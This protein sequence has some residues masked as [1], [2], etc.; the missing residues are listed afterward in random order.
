M[1]CP[2]PGLKLIKQYEGLRLC[3]YLDPVGVPTIGFGTTGADRP[4]WLGMPCITKRT[5]SKWLRSSVNHKYMPAVASVNR[6][7]REL[8]GKR[9][10]RRERAALASFAYNLGP[11]TLTDPSISTLARRLCSSEG[12][13]YKRR[14][15]IYR[16]EM[17][18]WNRAGGQ[19]LPGLTR[20]RRAE[21][22][23]A[24]KGRL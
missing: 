17:P 13:T 14:K 22:R 20:R 4:V 10:R 19:V 1:K 6:S 3:A 24:C 8:G 12:K 9:L 23:L 18:R 21:V 16:E 5:A 11:A 2:R 7:I 15:R